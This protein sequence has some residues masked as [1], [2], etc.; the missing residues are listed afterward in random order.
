LVLSAAK[1][2]IAAGVGLAQ[3]QPLALGF[4]AFSPT[5]ES[6]QPV[7]SCRGNYDN[8]GSRKQLTHS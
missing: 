3:H 7:K 5:Y 2:N 1:P 4:T 8:V 6:K